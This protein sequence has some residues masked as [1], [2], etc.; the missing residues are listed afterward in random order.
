[1]NATHITYVG[2][3]IAKDSLLLHLQGRLHPLPHSPAGLRGLVHLLQATGQPL[4]VVCEGTG[5]YEQPVL[6]T[7]HTAAI[8]VSV[9]QPARVRQ[10]ARAEGL[11]AKT[12]TID[13]QLLSR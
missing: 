10:F 5:G 1:M 11:L 13:A 8:P 7:L 12:D 3:D 6:R 4:Q 2:L 9:V